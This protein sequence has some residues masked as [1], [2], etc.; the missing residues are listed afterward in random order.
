VACDARKCITFAADPVFGLQV[1]V[2]CPDVP[3]NMLQPR[4]TWADKSAYDEQAQRLAEMFQE[5]F[6]QFESQVPPD[7]RLSKEGH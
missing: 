7:V 5:N 6:A 2:E 3:S 4:E 1:P